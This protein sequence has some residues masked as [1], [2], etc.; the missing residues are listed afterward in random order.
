MPQRPDPIEVVMQAAEQAQINRQP[1]EEREVRCVLHNVRR[2]VDRLDDELAPQYAE[3]DGALSK[4][5]RVNRLLS[6]ITLKKMPDEVL[7]KIFRFCLEG[8]PIVLRSKDRRA[9]PLA[10][11]IF[12]CDKWR[13]AIMETPDLWN[14]VFLDFKEFSDTN[15]MTNAALSCL[16]RCPSLPICL[17]T[18]GVV[19]GEFGVVSR[20]APGVNPVMK[21]VLPLAQRLQELRLVLPYTWLQSFLQ[22]PPGSVPLLESVDLEFMF[23][24]RPTNSDP[25]SFGDTN[26]HGN[27]DGTPVIS[28]DMTVFENAPS[29]RR[30]TF[31]LYYRKDPDEFASHPSSPPELQVIPPTAQIRLPWAQLTHLAFIHICVPFALAHA[32]LQQCVNLT[33]LNLTSFGRVDNSVVTNT[34]LPSLKFLQ[35]DIMNGASFSREYLQPLV[36]PALERLV[37]NGPSNL[38]WPPNFLSPLIARSNCHLTS[39]STSLLLTT[40]EMEVLLRSVPTLVDLELGNKESRPSSVILEKMLGWELVPRLSR[41]DF[42]LESK[43]LSQFVDVLQFRMDRADDSEAYAAIRMARVQIEIGK[44]SAKRA[45]SAMTRLRALGGIAEGIEFRS[46]DGFWIFDRNDITTDSESDSSENS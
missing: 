24:V 4:I 30:V 28:E 20:A 34:V 5:E 12:V 25:R 19:P 39:I 29:L 42:Y 13:H 36:L 22:S 2:E 27:N 46:A 3:L 14:H 23:G 37:L 10:P 15:R 43:L 8:G 9:M 31:R 6:S 33:S 41:F 1:I 16:S 32:L 17:Q 35:L 38:S 44:T 40:Q 26:R 45:K 21:L 7:G 18:D 11:L